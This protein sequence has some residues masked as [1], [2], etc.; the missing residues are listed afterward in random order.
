MYQIVSI[1][2]ESMIKNIFQMILLYTQIR[3]T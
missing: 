2:R 3:A 1:A